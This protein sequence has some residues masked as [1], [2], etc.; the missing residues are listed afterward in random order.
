[1]DK[2]IMQK[3]SFTIEAAIYVP[4]ML[5]LILVTLRGGISFYKESK[6]MQIDEGFTTLDIVSEF[7]TYQMLKEI[8]GEKTND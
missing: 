1:M 8:G 7:Y 4:M 6:E 3:G 2:K 5:F